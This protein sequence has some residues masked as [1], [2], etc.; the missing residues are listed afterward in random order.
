MRT[1]FQTILKK[2]V[3]KSLK[4]RYHAIM[5][6]IIVLFLTFWIN[7]KPLTE[8]DKI[9]PD[10][11][12]DEKKIESIS[13]QYP[14]ESGQ[15]YSV[16]WEWDTDF[17]KEQ[18]AAGA[19]VLMAA[20]CTVLEDPLPG[21]EENVYHGTNMLRGI[22]IMPGD[23]FSQ[24]RFIGPYTAYN[25]YKK[26][27]TYVGNRL[28]S[29]IGGGVCKISS[30]LYNVCTLSDLKVLE[31]HPHGM[32][33]PYVPYGQDATVSYGSKDFRFKNNT[34]FPIL[35]WAKCVDNRLYIGFYGRKLPP[36]VEWHHQ[37]L[38]ITKA[39]EIQ[40]RNT[41]LPPGTRNLLVRGMDGAS[42]KSWL[43][44]IADDNTVKV[45]SLGT[46][47]YS[48]MPYVYETN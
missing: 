47:Y 14:E 45:K 23:E 25:G 4:L 37:I 18:E 3:V 5:I 10:F 36:K 20:Y 27:P 21:E 46:D 28:I 40:R 38:K 39:P 7:V 19:F 30:T 1:I 24:N 13:L 2:K 35:I 22:I 8:K 29:T 16:P 6:L 34:K 12:A 32:P 48:P 33:V 43:T 15:V 11:F 44:I 26:G 41:K 17:L 9:K 42:V 31:R